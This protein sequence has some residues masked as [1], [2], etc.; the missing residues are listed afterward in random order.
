MYASVTFFE[1]TPF[2]PSSSQDANFV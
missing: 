1:E 2:F